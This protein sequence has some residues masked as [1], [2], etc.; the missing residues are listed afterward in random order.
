MADYLT[1]TK[2]KDIADFAKSYAHDLKEDKGAEYDR[3]LK[4]KDDLP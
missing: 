4:S 2:R 1:A 3:K